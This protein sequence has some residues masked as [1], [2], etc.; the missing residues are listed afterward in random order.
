MSFR[1]KLFV[2]GINCHTRN[3]KET[4]PTDWCVNC[5]HY[6]H[7]IPICH[8]TS[9]CLYCTGDHP[10]VQHKCNTCRASKDCEHVRCANCNDNHAA[11]DKKCNEWKQVLARQH[12]RQIRPNQQDTS[13]NTRGG[14]WEI[15]DEQGARKQSFYRRGAERLQNRERET[16]IARLCVAANTRLEPSREHVFITVMATRLRISARK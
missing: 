5:Q 16:S 13:N 8:K 10:T 11:N 4:K 14:E 6:G 2:S 12:K 7:T 15:G 9:R 1:G 3:F